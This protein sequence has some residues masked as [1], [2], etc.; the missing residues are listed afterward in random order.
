[1]EYEE[2]GGGVVVRFYVLMGVR[3]FMRERRVVR[4]GEDCLKLDMV[5]L[6]ARRVLYGKGVCASWR[7]KGT[8]I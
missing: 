7:D 2:E 5:L 6:G 3:A 1:M 8:R 4:G